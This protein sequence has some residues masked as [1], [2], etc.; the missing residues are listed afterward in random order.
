MGTQRRAVGSRAA[1][2]INQPAWSGGRMAK[3]A[4]D[5]GTPQLLDPSCRA[6]ALA[7]LWPAHRGERQDLLDQ[8]PRLPQHLLVAP[9]RRA[10]DEFG[11]PGIDIGG[12]PL[13]DRACIPDREIMQRVASGTLAVSF[14]QAGETGVVSP[15]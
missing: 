3:S 15:T 2:G 8:P 13:D 11:D 7:W 12:D 9:G 4:G 14:K 6:A 10:Q 1:G 5:Q